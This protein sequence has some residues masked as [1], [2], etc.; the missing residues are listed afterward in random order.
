MDTGTN[1]I[2]QFNPFSG[3]TPKPSTNPNQP[4]NISN[5]GQP[6][7][8]Q[9]PAVK[10]QRISSMP[11][12]GYGLFSM[13]RLVAVTPPPASETPAANTPAKPVAPKTETATAVRYVA[14][15]NGNIYESFLDNLAER[16]YSSTV[17][18]QIYEA[19]FGNNGNYVVMRYLKG[20]GRTIQTF[21]GLL[22]KEVL[23]G[24]GS[25][26][27]IK[28]VFLPENVTSVSLSPDTNNIF[29]LYPSGNGVV[30]ITM[31]FATGKKVQIFSS[32]FS[33]W[34]ADWATSKLITLTTKPSAGVPGYMYGLGTSGG[35]PSQMIGNVS[36][37]TTLTSS[38]G[39]FTLAAD[40][41]LRLSLYNN[42]TKAS[43]GVP[44]I[45]LPEK[46]T[47]GPKN[48]AIYCAVPK[49]IPTG[50]YPDSWYQG[51]VSFTDQIWQVNP[52]TGNTAL[53]DDPS[54]DQG[55]ED[56]DATNLGL[57]STGKHLIFV[58]KKDSI[59]WELSL[60]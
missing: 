21:V 39:K 38:D 37:L 31:N 50:N 48:D 23:G 24:D 53:L 25:T 28:G 58:N 6:T 5:G 16:H 41:A 8:N 59:L 55:G 33:E 14:R 42:S 18:P 26:N 17:I 43:V 4:V 51:E 12:A 36:G 46:C 52:T 22:P 32:A 13:Q 40:S 30:G 3:S 10:L 47:W 1:F 35:N 19:L 20:D 11:V 27:E 34:L 2:S 45:T 15:E 60:Q 44:L 54:A 56:M 49:N 29:Y 57:D 7:E 9:T